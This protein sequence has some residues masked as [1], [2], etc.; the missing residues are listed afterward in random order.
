MVLTRVD[1]RRPEMRGHLKGDQFG[2]SDYLQTMVSVHP[3]FIL[4]SGPLPEVDSG[5]TAGEST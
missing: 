3:T 5:K 4:I 2:H 1:R